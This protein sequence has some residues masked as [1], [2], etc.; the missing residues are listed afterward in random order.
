MRV[1]GWFRLWVC[2]TLIAVPLSAALQF[3]SQSQFWERLDRSTIK[4]CVT[5]ELSGPSHED[6]L[7]CAH[8]RGADKTFFQ[9]ENITPA[10][11]WAQGLGIFTLLDC[12]LTAL[13]VGLFF[14]VRWVVKGFKESSSSV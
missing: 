4:E 14:V 6:A 5:E 1:K 12:V 13:I 7:V 8:R 10:T 2:L 11:Y 3:R 9:H